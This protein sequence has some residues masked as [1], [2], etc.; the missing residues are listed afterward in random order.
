[1]VLDVNSQHA[2]WSSGRGACCRGLR[3]CGP[4]VLLLFRSMVCAGRAHVEGASRI[5][6]EEA[7][8]R[9]QMAF[10]TRLLVGA[11][12]KRCRRASV[13]R[14]RGA[15]AC[16]RCTRSCSSPPP[17]RSPPCRSSQPQPTCLPCS[18]PAGTS[19]SHPHRRTSSECT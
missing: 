17:E 3:C 7:L 4:A 19:A 18:C 1:M 13:R 15:L 6:G 14:V 16:L 12:L 5:I 8:A 9:V 11:R 10:D 2:P